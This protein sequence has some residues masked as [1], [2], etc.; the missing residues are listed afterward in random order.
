M[1]SHYQSIARAIYYLVERHPESPSLEELSGL[2][3][4]SPSHFQRVFTEFAGIS[5]K[6]FTQYLFLK[7]A[8]ERLRQGEAVLEAAY[9]SGL[10]SPGR[11]HDLSV[12]CE[13]LTPG[14]QRSGGKGLLIRYDWAETPFGEGLFAQTERGLCYF[15]LHEERSSE[16]IAE[17]KKRFP[18]ASFTEASGMAEVLAHAIFQPSTGS[19]LRLHLRGTNFQIQVWQALMKIPHGLSASYGTIARLVENPKAARAVGT[20]I[21]NNPVAVVIPCH[22]VLR[23]SGAIGGYRWGTDRKRALLAWENAPKVG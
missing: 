17:L 20:A 8:R 12:S 10:S 9:A 18:V 3:G 23:E 4:L 13:A 22:R 15:A 2:A 14:E 21:G 5:P 19:P 7:D 11:L 16:G 1:A 6:R